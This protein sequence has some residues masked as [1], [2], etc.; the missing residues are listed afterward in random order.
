MRFSRYGARPCR[1]YGR[2]KLRY[3]VWAPAYMRR[4]GLCF[5]W[6]RSYIAVTDTHW[7]LCFCRYPITQV[8]RQL[9]SFGIRAA[10]GSLA[11]PLG[12][13]IQLRVL[14]SVLS[15]QNQ[16][17]RNWL[18]AVQ[19]ASIFDILLQQFYRNLMPALSESIAFNYKTLLRYYL[20]QGVRYGMWLS[21]FLFAVFTA[22]G[23]HVIGLVFTGAFQQAAEVLVLLLAVAAFRWGIWLVD[24]LLL[25]A[26]RPGLSSALIILEQALCVG[27]GLYLAP[28]WGISGL[29][30]AY[31][32][33]L[34]VR[35]LLSWVLMQRLIIRVHIYIWQT[36]ISPLISGVLVYYLIHGMFEISPPPW[37]TG[38]VIA[39][40]LAGLWI[41]AF[42]TAVF[43]GWDDACVQELGR[44]VHLSSIGKPYA[45][46]LWQCVR[47]GARISPLHGRFPIVIAGMAEEQAQAISFSRPA[48]P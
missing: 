37:Q 40:L 27:G 22:F 3:W 48:N 18:V 44:A 4:N 21:V 29:L 25:A 33:A 12:V 45:W 36:L 16:L 28:R 14:D 9:L 6:A 24:A 35:T 26:E 5:S 10:L 42:L 43:G 17:W 39:A 38:F 13:I 31:A 20:T 8:G 15:G 7:K 30:S 32:I 34:L 2:T 47:L 1:L 46:G 19:I 11:V 41:Y 23:Q